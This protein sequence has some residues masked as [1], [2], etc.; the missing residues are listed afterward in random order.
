MLAYSTDARLKEYNLQT[1]VDD[2]QFF[3]PYDASPVIKQEVLDAHPEIAEVIGELIGKIDAETMI[4]L[5]YE[6]DV[7]KRNEKKVAEEYLKKIGL[8]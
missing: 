8:L 3:P 5:N 2:K 6:V 1:L 7:N 4:N